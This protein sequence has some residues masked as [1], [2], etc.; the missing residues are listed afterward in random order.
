LVFA[1][2]GKA[3]F[4]RVTASLRCFSAAD[5]AS[6]KMNTLSGDVS[7]L[8]ANFS[9][10]LSQA[11]G[12]FQTQARQ[13][14]QAADNLLK[15]FEQ[16]SPGTQNLIL[17]FLLYGGVLFSVIGA[18]NLFLGTT[19]KFI[20]NISKVADGVGKLKGVLF[21]LDG[22]PGLI[23]KI[24]GAF[25]ALFDIL[26]ANPIILIIAAIIAVGVGLYELY[27]HWTPFHKAVD[28]TWQ[29]L[30]TFFH[31]FIGWLQTAGKW[32]ANVAG[33]IK[34]WVTGFIDLVKHST[35]LKVVLGLMLAPLIAMVAPFIAIF[36]AVKH[37]GA[38]VDFFKQLPERIGGALEFIIGKV[39]GFFEKL[40]GQ[41]AGAVGDVVD[42]IVNFF[43]KLPYRVGYAIGF[44]IG[45]FIRLQIRLVQEGIKLATAV[46]G[47]ILN[48]IQKLPGQVWSILTTV[49][50]FFLNFGKKIVSDALQY[51]GQLLFAIIDEVQK[52]PGQILSITT[53]VIK[54]ILNFWRTVISDAIRFAAAFFNAIVDE[55]RKLPGQITNIMGGILSFI[56]TWGG[57][58]WD[59]A[60]KIG[61]NIWDGIVSFL[62]KLPGE[63]T[64][65]LNNVIGAFKNLIS[66]AFNIAKNFA[67]GL[68]DGFKKGLGINSPSYISKATDDIVNHVTGGTKKLTEQIR[69]MRALSNPFAEV[70]K[71]L[72]LSAPSIT[73]AITSG[74][75]AFA[76]AGGPGTAVAVQH[77]SS[78][79]ESLGPCSLSL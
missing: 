24:G 57:K 42:A 2:P 64:N 38:I 34:G 4:D 72:A 26:A 79:T 21:G 71:N 58:I 74:S 8:K 49:I 10:F 28:A 14:V 6:K 51:A 61:S 9:T 75:G 19:I 44:L 17:K 5:I 25:S 31:N 77:L 52:L 54:F 78:Y 69:Q 39:V 56:T 60:K 23:T 63:V 62:Q 70:A 41:I 53:T 76:G 18:M 40:P 22:A 59:Q 20:T 47:A 33:D 37:W 73:A 29:L 27:K 50:G 45:T 65:I 30:Q 36:E 11:G 67:S 3:G 15:K 1:N 43:A 32:I 68:W 35:A 66:D 12:P 7:K 16:L 13:L 46:M 48:E 55:V